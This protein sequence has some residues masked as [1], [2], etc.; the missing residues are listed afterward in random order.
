MLEASESDESYVIGWQLVASWLG[1]SDCL[2]EIGGGD[3]PMEI[4]GSNCPAET[5]GSNCPVTDWRHYKLS[6]WPRRDFR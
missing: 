6:G 2:A 3:H 5:G 4:G 1:D